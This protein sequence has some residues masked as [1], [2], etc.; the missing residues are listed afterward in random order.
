[1]MTVIGIVRG[2]QKG[3]RLEQVGLDHLPRVG[4]WVRSDEV[5]SLHLSLKL[6]DMNGT[7][8]VYPQTTPYFWFSSFEFHPVPGLVHVAVP[9]VP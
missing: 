1:M 6:S 4:T 5:K 9:Q 3:E 2:K 7:V 8:H